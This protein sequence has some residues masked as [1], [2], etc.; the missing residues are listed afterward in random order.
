MTR[1]GTASGGEAVRP[2]R[3]PKA[4]ASEARRLSREHAGTEVWTDSLKTRLSNADD[5]DLGTFIVAIAAFSHFSHA[6]QVEAARQEATRAA[7]EERRQE[8]QRAAVAAQEAE[9]AREREAKQRARAIA[10]HKQFR[11]VSYLALPAGATV[12]FLGLPLFGLSVSPADYVTEN[13]ISRLHMYL[14][15]VVGAFTLS[16]V[17]TIVSAQARGK[18]YWPRIAAFFTFAIGLTTSAI[19]LLIIIGA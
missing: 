15:V 13:D 4:W 7:E 1:G 5:D 2:E 11:I 9:L 6:R 3:S 8:A 12:A 17:L 16:L 18:W 10:K 14:P 19:W